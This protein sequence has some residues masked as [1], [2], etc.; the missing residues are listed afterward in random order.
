[1]IKATTKFGDSTWKITKG[2]RVI[3]KGYKCDTLYALHVSNV[4]NHV[5]AV[6]EVPKVSSWHNQLGHMSVKGMQVLS[7]LG[8][9]PS[10][11]FSEFKHCEYC[12]FGKHSQLPHKVTLQ[13][14]LTPLDLVHSDVCQMP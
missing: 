8:Y 14:R 5:I 12:I 4:K 3:A 13:Q 1:M 6:I 9:L 7:Q 11:K 2:A 10:L